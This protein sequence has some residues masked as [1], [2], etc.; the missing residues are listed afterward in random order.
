LFLFPLRIVQQDARN[1]IH[2][3]MPVSMISGNG[4]NLSGEFANGVTAMRGRR[5]MD[6]TVNVAI[7]EVLT[8]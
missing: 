1:S 2:V 7:F 5:P 6:R 8:N 4:Q 3:R